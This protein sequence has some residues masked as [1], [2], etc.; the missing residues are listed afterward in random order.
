VECIAVM[1]RKPTRRVLLQNPRPSIFS[2]FARSEA[3]I[4]SIY[5]SKRKINK[6][7]FHKKTPSNFSGNEF[8]NHASDKNSEQA[9]SS[10]EDFDLSYLLAYNRENK[11][12]ILS[13]KFDWNFFFISKGVV[14]ADFAFFDPKPSDFHGVKILLQTYLDERQWDVSGFVDLILGQTTVGTVI[15]VE[16][17]EDDGVYSVVTALNLGRYKARNKT[18]TI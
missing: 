8:Q 6:S 5:R 14:R 13:D 12:C 7:K 4:A 3:L 10:D 11:G 18:C 15:K 16:D 9:E 1:P 17:D 2:R